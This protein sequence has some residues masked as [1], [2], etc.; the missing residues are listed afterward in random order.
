MTKEF[1]QLIGA[2]ILAFLLVL[3]ASFLFSVL[4]K[5]PLDIP[6][7]KVYIISEANIGEYENGYAN[8]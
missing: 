8:C 2:L 3:S 1:L 6:F 4:Y 7:E 5:N